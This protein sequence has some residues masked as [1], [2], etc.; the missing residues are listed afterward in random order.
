MKNENDA[1]ADSLLGTQL[2]AKIPHPVLKTLRRKL[3][4][5]NFTRYFDMPLML[6]RHSGY[7]F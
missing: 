7:R 4:F 1:K 5:L 3:V 6:L 2:K